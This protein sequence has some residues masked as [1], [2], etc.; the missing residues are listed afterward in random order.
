MSRN[1]SIRAVLT[2]VLCCLIWVI[3]PHVNAQDQPKNSAWKPPELIAIDPEIRALLGKNTACDQLN[4]DDVIELAQ[5]AVRIGE[6]RSLIRDKALAEATLASG[7]IGRGDVEQAFATLRKALQDAID[8][9]NGVLEADILISLASEAQLKGNT[10]EAANLLARA[11]TVSEKNSS[12]YEK[13][14]ALGEMGRID[15]LLSKREEAARSINEALEIDRINGYRFEALHLVYRGY[16][17]GTS[18]KLDQALDSLIQARTKALSMTDGYSFLMAEN[19]YA[20]GLVQ[21]GKTDQAVADLTLLKQN[22]VQSFLQDAEKQTCLASALELPV[23][24]LTLLEGLANVLEAA[25]QKENEREIW[26]ETFNYSRDHNIVAGEA[27]A[28]HK[29]ADLQN[30]LN[31][32]DEALKYYAIAADLYRTL[33]NEPS[34]AQV[35]VSESL[36]LIKA[37]RGKEAVPLEQD[38]AA[39]AKRFNLRWAEFTAYGVLAEIYQP[40][41]QLEEA[42]DALEKSLAVIRPG[43]FDEELDNKAVLEDY[44][45]LADVYRSLKIP[46]REL[47]AIVKAFLVANHLKD[48]KVKGNVLGYLDQRLKDL[49]IRE[50]VNERQNE[51]Q[52]VESLLYSCVL[53]LRDGAPS[54]PDDNHTNVDRLFGLPQQ[55]TQEP[56]GV[57]AL[58]AVLDQMSS[59]LGTEKLPMLIAIARY[60]TASGSDPVLAEKYALASERIIAGSEALMAFEAENVCVLALSYSRQGKIAQATSRVEQ[61]LKLANQFG[62]QQSLSYANTVNVLVQ[63]NIGKIAGAKGSLEQL[64][65]IQGVPDDPELHIELAMSLAN[66]GLVNDASS[67]VETAIG[68]LLTKGDKEAAARAYVRVAVTLNSDDAAAQSLQ[69]RYLQS[70]QKIY[71]ELRA[72]PE[73]ATTLILIGEHSFRSGDMRTAIRIFT[74]ALNLAEGTKKNDVIGQALLD[75][76]NVYQAQRDFLHASEFHKR[77]VEAFSMVKAPLQLVFARENLSEDYNALH[78]SDEALTELLEAKRIA[79]QIPVP[80]QYFLAYFLSQVYRKQGQFEKGIAVLR[81]AVETT[82]RGDDREHC[83]YAHLGIAELDAFIGAWDDALIESKA[84][85]NLFEELDNKKGQAASWADMTA[86]YSDRTSSLKDFDQAKQCYAKAHELGYGQDLE[87]DLA[88]LYLQT[89]KYADLERI[90]NSTIHT[91]SKSRDTDCQ[92]HALLSLSESKRLQGDLKSARLALNQASGLAATSSDVYLHG[93]LLYGQAKQL[94]S[95]EKLQAALATYRQL[96]DLIETVK[97]S[98]DARAQRAVSENYAY[99]Y[100]ELVSLLYSMSVRSPRDQLRFASESLEYAETNK[101]NQFVEAWGRTFIEQMRRSLPASVQETERSLISRRDRA[102]AQLNSS[103]SD[104]K[105]FNKQHADAELASVRAKVKTFVEQLRRTAPQYAAVGYPET[106][107][108]ASLPLK[109]NETLVEFKVTED[110]ALAWIVQKREDRDNQLVSFYKIPQSRAWF[111]DRISILRKALNSGH[112]EIVDWKISEEIFRALFPA[113]V[114][115]TLTESQ[116]IIFIPDDVLFALPFELFSPNATKSDFVF[117]KKASTYYPSAVSFRLARTAVLGSN[118]QEAFLGLADPITSPDDDRFEAAKAIAVGLTQ[119]AEA[120]EKISQG[121]SAEPDTLKSRGFSF[122]RLPGTALEVKTI[123][124]LLRE[125]NENFEIRIGVDATKNALVDTDLTQF[126][127]LH[128]ATHGVLPVDSNIQEPALVLSYDGIAPTHMLLSLSEVLGLKLRSE[129]VVLSACNTGSGRISK[130]E[131]V[132]SLGRAFLAAGSSSVTVSLWQV[133]DE[134]TAMLMQQYYRNLLNNQPKSIALADAR[135]AVF[136]KGFKNPFFWAPF[137]LIGE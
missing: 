118:W 89:G 47:V 127:F 6:S 70:A 16:Y 17:L 63:L 107:R 79:P 68:K 84:A 124:A 92:A 32:S 18:G 93:R 51:G 135:Y 102:L 128:F 73:E 106:I 24:H 61:C 44:L 13:S 31:K 34:L 39:Y 9:K 41:G 104:D 8:S 60:Y 108:I 123:G 101:A 130:A 81:Q 36:L 33:Q 57:T 117:L 88:E 112:P 43:P 133:S 40:A 58:I 74:D 82:S 11:L 37:G 12:L 119:S 94:T 10:P 113:E 22:N 1:S 7:Y 53:Y 62:T 3:V 136:S 103:T 131:G 75:L 111:L 66:T 129:S 91:C 45:R 71:H 86:I 115:A 5:Q 67:Q 85:L 80:N 72:H 59:L 105:S 69:L 19:S 4:V 126:R 90:A 132:M 50:L 83:G 110:C 46:T 78:R 25:N 96:I 15:L 49:K 98:L 116:H 114:S 54:K 64:L 52:L 100:D 14:R 30:Q 95:E 38:V 125:H 29:V 120:N 35:R 27:E 77:A 76:G 97:G 99:I 42:R 28:A 55:I 56:G 121:L 26:E 134:S 21:K 137:I 48:D 2:V 65:A 23:L 109:N 122:E 87:L 20:F